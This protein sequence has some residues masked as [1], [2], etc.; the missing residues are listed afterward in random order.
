[1]EHRHASRIIQL[2]STALILGACSDLA[3]PTRPENG[4][5]NGP[6]ALMSVTCTASTEAKTV[7]CAAP[8]RAGGDAVFGL[9]TGVRAVIIGGQGQNV[10][11]TSSNI[12]VVA[13][14]FAFDVSV[15]NLISQALGTTD[16]QNPDP[17][18][19]R[20]FFDSGPT[21]TGSGTVTVANPDGTG[22][23]TATSQPYFQYNS[24]LAPDS[25]T[26]TKTWKL[27]FTPDV[28]AFTFTVYVSA[29][30]QY[31]DGYV[32]GTPYVVTLNPSE[33][34]TLTGTVRGVTG[35]EIPSETVSWSTSDATTASVSG[36][37]VTAGASNGFAT[38]TASSGPRPAPYTTAVSVCPAMVV[39]DGADIP[40]SIANTDCFSSYGDPNGRPT[41]SYY[42]DLYRVTLTAGQTLTVTMDS[43]DNLDTYLL[44]AAPG[45]GRLVAANDDDDT[46]ALGVGSRMVYT[47]EEP[48]VYVIEAS[49]FNGLDTGA[50]TLHVTIS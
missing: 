3:E 31:P 9:D 11:L 46:E 16:G 8:N 42:A 2:L 36:S 25:V 27:Q 28:T 38:L 21:S 32:D 19:V 44:L 10:V 23:F 4:G 34:R 40:A 13:D 33:T 45:T 7:S 1:M 39:T 15:Q 29:A 26:P 5:P 50:Y 6:A 18:G 48:G 49:T 20:V 12:Q 37:Q 43:G 47:A 30:V 24:V 41:T 35:R 22:T 17:A 14:T